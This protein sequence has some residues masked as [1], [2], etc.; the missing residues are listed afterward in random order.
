MP[1][2][3]ILFLLAALDVLRAGEVSGRVVDS[4]TNEPLARVQVQL[5]GGGFRAQTAAD[6]TFRFPY[7]PGG[8]YV[9]HVSTVGY[10]LLRQ[11]FTLADA[12][13]KEFDVVL[14]PSMHSRTESV[15]V[16]AE[17]FETVRA[18]GPAELTLSGGELKNL[19]SVLAD[20]PLRAVQSLPGV[21]SNDDFNS[22]FSLRG[23]S[24]QRIGLYLD[25]VLLHAP[26]HM[27][28]GEPSTGSLT[29]FNGDML[30]SV[31]L[32]EGAW[33][34]RFS[35]RTAG[36]L[37][38][39]MRDGSRSQT[40]FR[41]TA[42][43]SN[44][45]VMA[46]GPIGKAHRGSWMAGLRKSY[47]QYL[48]SR[49]SD[50]PALAFGFTDFNGRLSYDLTERHNLS[51]SLL[52]AR[53]GLDR[54]DA[55]ARLGLNSVMT[56]GYDVTLIN[57]AS[58]YAP[59]ARFLVRNRAAWMRERGDTRNP[60]ALVLGSDGYGEWTGRTDASWI[61]GGS[62]T[63]DFGGSLRRV[64]DDGYADRYQFNPFAV[65]PLDRYRG[66]ATLPGAY[67]Q[68][69]LGFAAGR[70]TLAAG[71]RWDRSSVTRSGVFS[72]RASLAL[73]PWSPTR[74]QFGFGQ[75]A[76][77]PELSEAYST[78]GRPSLAPERATHYEL[79]LDQRLGERT[80][81]RVEFYNRQDRDLLFRSWLDPRILAGRVFNPPVNDPIRNS[82]RGYA[83]GVQFL[84]QRRSANGL[85][86]WVSYAYGTAK[87]LDGITQLWFLS[88]YDQRHTVN[89]YGSYRI[90]PT[91]NVS[92]R[93]T[94]GS[95]FPVPGFLRIDQGNYYL[96]PS[97]NAVR[98]DAYQRADTRINKAFV[99]DKWKL[100]FYA[101][102]INVTNRTNRRFDTFNGYN[103]KTGQADIRFDRMIP[104]LP[105]AGI[106]LEK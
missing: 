55:K 11:E 44:A 76:Q 67:A 63:L 20:D 18:A 48:I 16:R 72:P 40:S 19:A 56:S 32:E 12:E 43:A 17:P 53:S 103:G 30:D 28:Q 22:A 34:P 66:T 84:V 62:N 14:T 99:Y 74:I 52:E 65:R 96:G 94:Y 78:F 6:G 1:L 58:R 68:Q 85:T 92:A 23:A 98:M 7:V 29:V 42:S 13:T 27:I 4:R 38:V 88:D 81:A 106:V 37:D 39:S 87:L 93:W 100:T 26:F 69:S 86:G 21:T 61:W 102:V 31:A 82:L 51:L 47:L 5:A 70:I 33:S 79:T 80:R 71:G 75:Y 10:H 50:D 73:Q 49:L 46:E 45:G 64:R 25:D 90:R 2:R 3:P 83:R 95:G 57:L 15:E 89:A 8:E 59:H 41:A 91:V 54:S 60:S 97:R 77:F 105:S 101:E 104:V 36:I 24:Y 35:D 9:L